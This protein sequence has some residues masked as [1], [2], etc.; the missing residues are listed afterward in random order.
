MSAGKVLTL[1]S[2]LRAMIIDGVCYSVMVGVAETY[3]PK[4]AV[5][6]GLGEVAGALVATAPVV[7]GAILQLAAPALLRRVGSYARFCSLCAWAQGAMYLPLA[8]VALAGPELMAWLR[9]H[10][11]V[12]AA[13]VLVFGIAMLYW[14]ASLACGPAWSTL[15]GEIVPRRMHASYFAWRNRWLQL[16]TLGG[17]LLNGAVLAGDQAGVLR[18]FA[19]VFLGAAVLRFVSAWYLGRY[20]APKQ[21]PRE[22]RHVPLGE[23]A[24]RLRDSHAGRWM[25]YVAGAHIATQMAQP[26]LNPF[27]LK[28]LEMQGVR[29]SLLLAAWYGGKMLVY[30]T[31]GRLAARRGSM[32]LV[33]A[34]AAGLVLLPLYWLAVPG[35]WVLVAAQVVSGMCW[36]AWE[37]SVVL[38]NYDAVPPRERTSVYTWFQLVNE[39]SKTTGS[40]VGSGVFAG[41]GGGF[42]GYAAAFW[43][44]AGM[45]LGSALML[46]WVGRRQ[47][48]KEE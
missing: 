37:L 40:L 35:Y 4:F 13:W 41:V 38:M 11:G 18:R 24:A 29:Y 21:Q 19:W 30:S 7:L 26:L 27:M 36:G 9:G 42:V 1:R 22:E 34:S 14:A 48:T 17:I 12:W 31:A 25:M 3:I 45:R 23:L 46:G 10:G 44:S 5:D 8:G 2:D 33:R 32:A 28:Q 43:A 15:A 16:A 20:S 47:G 6:L 39:S